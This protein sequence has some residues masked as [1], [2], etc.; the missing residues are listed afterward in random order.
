GQAIPAKETEALY[1]YCSEDKSQEAGQEA[2]QGRR[3][4]R[5]QGLGGHGGED[6]RDHDEQDNCA[7][8]EAGLRVRE[9]RVR[10]QLIGLARRLLRCVKPLNRGN[11]VMSVQLRAVRLLLPSRLLLD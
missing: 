9:R 8:D 10:S 5:S 1:R 2:G 6:W 7:Q 3:Q 4:C 11:V